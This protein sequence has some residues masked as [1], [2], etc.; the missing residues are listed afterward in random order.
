MNFINPI[1]AGVGLACVAIPILIHILLR[2]RRKP[3]SFG[4]MRFVIE[5]Y[6]QQRRRMR[7]EQMLLL[8]CRCLIVALL[9]MAIG[10]PILDSASLRGSSGPKTVYLVV[11]DSLTASAA[12]G[13]A[14]GGA[15]ALDASRTRALALLE[16]LQP[17][18]GDRV[19]LIG[20]A[21]PA[22]GI[23]MPPTSEVSVVR[24]LLVDMTATDS[25]ADVAGAIEL[26]RRD[27]GQGLRAGVGARAGVGGAVGADGAGGAGGMPSTGVEAGN[28]N[29]SSVVFISEFRAGTISPE[30]TLASL[31]NARVIVRSP[32]QTMLDNV[33][34]TSVEA[35]RTIVV[36]EARTI[37]VR[38]TLSRSGPFQDE[39]FTARVRIKALV[40]SGD[41]KDAAESSTAELST[42]IGANA[43]ERAAK[44]VVVDAKFAPG[45]QTA[46]G[47]G[48]VE[49]PIQRADAR[50]TLR[51]IVI[52]ASVDQ[53][54]I[55]RDDIARVAV[56][57][58]STID[59]A[60]LWNGPLGQA[61]NVL[62]FTAADWLSL[63]SAP[64]DDPLAPRRATGDVRLTVIDP[65]RELTSGGAALRGM[66]A[67]L[68]PS[69][70]GLPTQ[71][72]AAVRAAADA[73]AMVLVSPPSKEADPAWTNSMAS[74]FD[75]RTTIDPVPKSFGEGQAG[76]VDVGSESLAARFAV[77]TSSGSALL[78]MLAAELP[79]LVR[80][81][82]I[83]KI[84]TLRGPAGSYDAL[85]ALES[86]EPILAAL[87]IGGDAGTNNSGA[88]RAGTS[89]LGASQGN[90]GAAN[91]NA[92]T[93][94]S[95][96][97]SRGESRGLLL[98][99]A[100]A[101]DLLWTDLPTKPLM[102]P[103]VQELL[104]QGVGKA[105]GVRV[106][107]A[108]STAPADARA[109][110]L[111][112]LRGML[113]DRAETTEANRR[114][115]P[116]APIRIAGAYGVRTSDA[117]VARVLIVNPD[118]AASST[119]TLSADAVLRTFGSTSETVAFLEPLEEEAR[120]AGVGSGNGSGN[121]SEAPVEIGAQFGSEERSPPISF[122]LLIAAGVLALVEL[123]MARVFSHATVR[124]NRVG[125]VR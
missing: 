4:A 25:R 53:D 104:R 125:E 114:F 65:A 36:G 38:V 75:L 88:G 28:T 21:G 47:L 23:V 76:G 120:G 56:E 93:N 39:A 107:T 7:L 62:D 97:A 108:G 84:T 111:V 34:V 102:V 18:R 3:I 87:T 5:A 52:E 30:Q 73:G 117:A 124:A 41:E 69:P 57:A 27:M 115:D 42:A 15:S 22:R 121:G 105:Q 68:I 14:S 118:P 99:L 2:R 45:Q 70:D 20:L 100:V 9:A 89:N 60:L 17:A 26:I 86:G 79:E 13:A 8:A 71:A 48:T 46:T 90:A 49:V 94:A 61:R 29:T 123:V 10:K 6:Q 63:A 106:L 16:D 77:S 59:V 12:V 44:G 33:A 116:L 58:R 109:E 43:S 32:T 95:N 1:L 83:Y 31:G 66:D 113:G 98:Y 110:E 91:A 80:P 119:D 50:G 96:A 74:A 37:P 82:A 72:W 24:G 64:V 35:L 103:L 85:L 112:F 54:A 81:V 19:A 78:S 51:P 101:P 55:R 11:D 40:A 122:P 92:N 67:I